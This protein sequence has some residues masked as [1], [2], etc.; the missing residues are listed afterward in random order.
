MDYMPKVV[1]FSCNF[2]WGYLGDATTVGSQLKHWVRVPCTGKIDPIYI[3]Q[4]LERG[5]D[6]VLVLGCPMGNCHFQDGNY[7]TQ[8]RIY[9]LQS[10]LAAYGIEE[11]RVD[12]ALS[13]DAD[14]R[15]IPHLVREMELRLER[16]GP[17]K[18]I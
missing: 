14:G 7:R 3:L 4:A 1:C 2:G 13:S 16:M 9:L 11:E 5:V 17:P 8:K 6:G 15:R 10:V 12:I 18:R